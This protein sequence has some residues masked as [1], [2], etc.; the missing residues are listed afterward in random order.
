MTLYLLTPLIS[1]ADDATANAST[2]ARHAMIDTMMSA[3]GPDAVLE[4]LASAGF[5]SI[6]DFLADDPAA[7]LALGDVL[8]SLLSFG[9]PVNAELPDGGLGAESQYFAAGRLVTDKLEDGSVRERWYDWTDGHLKKIVITETSGFGPSATYTFDK[10]GRLTEKTFEDDGRI[11]NRKFKYD[12]DG[13]VIEEIYGDS[14]KGGTFKK[15]ITKWDGYDI[16]TIYDSKGNVV[17]KGGTKYDENGNKV[18]ETYK[19]GTGETLK[20]TY[21]YN[22]QGSLTKVTRSENGKTTETVEIEYHEDGS[23]KS[24]TRKDADGNVIEHEEYGPKDDND[25]DDTDL[26][27]PDAGFATGTGDG[28]KDPDVPEPGEPDPETTQ[29]N[30]PDGEDGGHGFLPDH[31]SDPTYGTILVDPDKEMLVFVEVPEHRLDPTYGL[32]DPEGGPNDGA[33]GVLPGLG[34][35]QELFVVHADGQ[36]SVQE[37][38]V[39]DADQVLFI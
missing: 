24:F 37:A 16:Y 18:Y 4:A 9:G 11:Q 15:E 6:D 25:T 28:L 21:E 13:N 10:D 32:V 19:A 3:F 27:D 5:A 2:I 39:I 26:K 30:S 12:S 14:T 17:A 20:D 7:G 34:G 23:A 36:F 8:G 35:V 31:V 38:I 1:G 33:G 22:D 29:P